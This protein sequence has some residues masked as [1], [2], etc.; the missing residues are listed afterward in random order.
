ML[1]KIHLQNSNFNHKLV[2]VQ[3][4]ARVQNLEHEPFY[5]KEI[6]LEEHEKKRL[7][8]LHRFFFYDKK[9]QHEKIENMRKN[10]LLKNTA[11]FKLQKMA[12]KHDRPGGGRAGSS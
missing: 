10:A 1:Q 2:M 3:K 4:N 12:G 6:A 8:Q 7:D 11:S 5:K 9:K